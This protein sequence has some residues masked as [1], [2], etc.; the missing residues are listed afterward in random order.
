LAFGHRRFAILDLTVGGHQPFI[1]K[2]RLGENLGFW[3]SQH[4]ELMWRVLSLEL[5]HKRF[6]KRQSIML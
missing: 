6:I 2:K 5:W 4:P 3:I 1:N